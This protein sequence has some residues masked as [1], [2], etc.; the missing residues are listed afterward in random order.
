[1]QLSLVDFN[2][3]LAD[4]PLWSFDAR[5]GRLQGNWAPTAPWSEVKPMAAML[6]Q[7]ARSPPVHPGAAPAGDAA[8]AAVGDAAPAA[9][10]GAVPAAAGETAPAASDGGAT[11]DAAAPAVGEDDASAPERG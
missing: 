2:A 10:G 1:M 9:V 8:P 7:L 11:S 4:I 5:A 6:I 3:Q